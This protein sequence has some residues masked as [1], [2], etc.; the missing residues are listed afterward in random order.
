[1]KDW[2]ESLFPSIIFLTILSPI[3][4][5]LPLVALSGSQD[6]IYTVKRV[7]GGDTI[8]LTNGERVRLIGVDTPE[9]NESK[10]LC[11]DAER[12]GR[13]IETIKEL[14]KKA[15]EFTKSLV[16]RK[17]VRLGYDQ[18]NAYIGHKDKYGGVLAY[19]YLKDGTFLNAEIIRQGYGF[20]YTRFPFQ[21]MEE[22][23]RYEREARENERGLW[24][25]WWL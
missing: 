17:E 14:G 24:G 22:F 1:M 16:D 21:Y 9:V 23:R 19:V 15:S 6:K 3:F 10:K 8:L 5:L 25:E 12:T 18:A 4:L 13:D 11:R 7:V 2:R 20:A